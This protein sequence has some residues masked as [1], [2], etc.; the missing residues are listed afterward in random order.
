[1]AAAS[2]MRWLV[3][4]VLLGGAALWLWSSRDAR[5]TSATGERAEAPSQRAPAE[6]VPAAMVSPASEASHTTREL[7]T[8]AEVRASPA[9]RAAY[10]GD[11]GGHE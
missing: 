2:H 4:L 5:S 9:V 11:H 7:P 6:L 8:P 1:M 10:L 3:L